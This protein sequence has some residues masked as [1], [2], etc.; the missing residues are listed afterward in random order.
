MPIYEFKCL[1]CNEEF[2]VL[3]KS[4][5]EISNVRCKACGSSKIERLMSVVNSLIKE[6]TNK[7]SDKPRVAES[8]SCPTGTCTHLELPG[9]QK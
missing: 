2:E 1:D 6:T 5:E 3:L 8:H 4:K 9:Y 7:A